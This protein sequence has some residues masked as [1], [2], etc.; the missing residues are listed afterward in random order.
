MPHA[1]Q[2]SQ[3][4]E[5]IS[6]KKK[7]ERKKERMLILKKKKQQKW[8]FPEVQEISA[9]LQ[10]SSLQACPTWNLPSQ[11]PQCLSI[12]VPP[13]P[14]LCFPGSL[15]NKLIYNRRTTTIVIVKGHNEDRT[16]SHLFCFLLDPGTR[17]L[18]KWWTEWN[19]YEQL[20]KQL[21]SIENN[22]LNVSARKEVIFMEKGI[23]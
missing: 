6:K 19:Y 21:W 23:V 15:M 3:K 22:I 10:R 18:N 5:K 13:L 17:A 2:H 1:A 7:P 4:I 12:N 16:L 8:G 9:V 20:C 14:L 11:P